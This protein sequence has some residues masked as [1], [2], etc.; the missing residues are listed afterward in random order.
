MRTPF[1]TDYWHARVVEGREHEGLEDAMLAALK[2][3]PPSMCSVTFERACNLQCLHCIY[4]PEAS[5][6]RFSTEAGLPELVREAVRQLPSDSPRLLHEGRIIRP[7]HV[8]VLADAAS[9]RT[10]LRVGL[11]DNGTYLRCL[12]RFSRRGFALDWLDISLDGP[13]EVH[14]QQRASRIA[15]RDAM[16]GLARAREVVKPDG[17]VT[18]L[19]TVTELNHAELVRTA[20]L[21]FGDEVV[22]EWHITTLSP[23][24]RDIAALE[25]HDLSEVW[26]Q[27]RRAFRQYGQ[28][29]NSKQRI[30]FRLYRHQD[31][32]KLA[33]VVGP[34]AVLEALE[35]PTGFTPGEVYLTLEDVP[36]VFSPLSLWPGETFLIDA[37]GAYRT[38]YSISRTLVELRHGR[39][40]DG[41][42]LRGFTVERL[43]PGFDLMALHERC[44]DQWWR[45]RG[46]RY[47]K[48]EID[49]LR[50]L[51]S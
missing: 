19:F 22:D 36:I 39:S 40:D 51:R 13:E 34:G 49:V 48:E 20:H 25:C 5:S 43:R 21:L 16:A 6:R 47:L 30:F 23:A 44:V 29:S 33:R 42:D 10:D 8:D 4:P 24:R 45:F 31:L 35:R 9:M 11:L 1:S 50:A 41:E 12:D 38:A 3:E 26:T 18:S 28:A 7:W 37:D 14:N 27:A 17:R 46:R 15:Y 2:R 32:L